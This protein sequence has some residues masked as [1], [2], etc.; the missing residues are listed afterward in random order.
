MSQF[1]SENLE[2][3]Y[4]FE[5][6][7]RASEAVLQSLDSY[8]KDSE[9]YRNLYELE[10]LIEYNKEMVDYMKPRLAR[11]FYRKASLALS[12]Q[13]KDKAMALLNKALEFEPN[14]P[15]IHY[16][17]AKIELGNGDISASASRLKNIIDRMSPS[18]KEEE[19]CKDMI[20]FIYD[21]NMAKSLNLINQGK[22]AYA[23][24]I[25]IEIKDYCK[26][27]RLNICNNTIIETMIANIEK[28]IYEDHI[29]VTKR[30]MSMGRSDIALDF[31]NDT[32][33]YFQRNRG[34]ISDTMTFNSLVKDI[35]KTY[36]TD[37]KSL[38][39]ARNYEAKVEK[40]NKARSLAAII[41]GS[42]EDDILREI[43]RM[44]GGRTPVNIRLDSIEDAAA[45]E[46]IAEK[47]PQYAQDSNINPLESIEEIEKDYISSSDNKLPEKS[48]AVAQSQSRSLDK[49]IEDKFFESRTFMRVNNFEAALEVLEKANRLAQID[50]EKEEVEKMYTAAIREISARRMSKAEYY[51]FEG[52]VDKSDSLV[53]LTNDLITSYAMEKDPEII[54][55]MDSYLRAIDKKVCEKKQEEVDVF[56]YNI[57][58]CIQRNDFHTADLLITRAMQIKG[59]YDCRLDK[60]RVR[61]LKVQIEKPM[62][63]LELKETSLSHLDARDTMEFIRSYAIIEEFYDDYQLNELSV[64]HIRLRNILVNF[65]NDR[66]V[67]KAMEDLI[68]HK[69]YFGSL[70]ALAALKEMGYKP[71]HT[72]KVQSKIGELMSL[73]IVK[74]QDKIR[75][76]NKVN[77]LYAEDRWFR[78][79]Y[80]SY[81]KHLARWQKENI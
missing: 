68:N 20:A 81:R 28:G 9:I 14:N 60:H 1:S 51:I 8:K 40:L 67:I 42:Y 10:Y 31:A 79:F 74:R 32:Y 35:V 30:A 3:T 66:L 45:H 25:L 37:A 43:N 38:N 76:S 59:S 73:D 24:D 16:E 34:N 15:M 22:F 13:E 44:Q 23:N 61:Q 50:L 7:I 21:K 36:V 33:D 53:A 80:R 6:Q 78:S 75:E 46:S 27:D 5:E 49:A 72:S 48:L 41:G 12:N 64:E 62:E 18:Q 77:D 56:V 63:Y 54:K 39:R 69:L 55:I 47:Y 57:I 52:N 26:D 11:S 29:K 17:I 71:S 4:V 70:E 2:M 19:L 58:D 65:N